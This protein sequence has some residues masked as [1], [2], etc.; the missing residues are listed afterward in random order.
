MLILWILDKLEIPWII[1]H[2]FLYV[3]LP[4]VVRLYD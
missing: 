1:A 4:G 3:F 2:G